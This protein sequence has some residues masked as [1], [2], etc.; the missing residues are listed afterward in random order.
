MI[1]TIISILIITTIIWF[2]SKKLPFNICPVC[3]GVLLTWTGLLIVISLGQLSISDYQLPTAILAGGTVV[4]I[5]SK[6]EK[7][8]KIKFI[9]LWKTTFVILGFF[10][11]YSLV[12]SDWII[13][14]VG[15]I[16]IIIVTVMLKKTKM[17]EPSKKLEEIQEKLKNCC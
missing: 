14:I 5:M 13:S 12:S 15:I 11:V 10:V 3:T 17:K 2:V 4:G 9:L 7:Y 16:L 1:I 6:L 8:I